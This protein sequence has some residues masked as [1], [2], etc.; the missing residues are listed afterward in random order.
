MAGTVITLSVAAKVGGGPCVSASCPRTNEPSCV[1]RLPFESV[2]KLPARV[3]IV[4]PKTA[5]TAGGPATAGVWIAATRNQPVPW[6]ARSSGLPVDWIAP[7][8]VMFWIAPT[9]T[10]SPICW[11]FVPPRVVDGPLAPACVCESASLKLVREPLKP[12]VL[13][14]AMSFAVTSSMVWWARRPLIAANKLLIMVWFALLP[15]LR[16][17]GSSWGKRGG[18]RP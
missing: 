5:G 18:R 13:T 2:V 10:P 12:T 16:P 1:T 17:W 9:W 7:E 14:F 15:A 11:A 6:T 4:V 3:Y 8:P